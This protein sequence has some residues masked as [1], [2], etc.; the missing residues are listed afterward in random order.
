[1]VNEVA[2]EIQFTKQERKDKIKISCKFSGNS[3]ISQF[4]NL[5]SFNHSNALTIFEKLNQHFKYD[6]NMVIDFGELN[7]IDVYGLKI[8]LQM[9]NKL[10]NNGKRLTLINLSGV[11]KKL[12]STLEINKIIKIQENPNLLINKEI[13][14]TNHLL[15]FSH[16][17]NTIEHVN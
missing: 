8:L 14:Q 10:M 13:E 17:T 16:I 2:S 1:M 9:N 15:E 11:V 6:K 4:E 7:S 12:L 3:L 5:N